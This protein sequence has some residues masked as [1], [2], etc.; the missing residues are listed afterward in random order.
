MVEVA[1]LK[2]GWDSEA[3]FGQDFETYVELRCSI[4]GHPIGI[5]YVKQKMHLSFIFIISS[6]KQNGIESLRD[7]CTQCVTDMNIE[8]P[9]LLVFS[10]KYTS[11]YISWS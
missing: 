9:L 5:G 2:L 11:F 1:K 7:I 10:V 6:W 4:Y 8:M 3:W